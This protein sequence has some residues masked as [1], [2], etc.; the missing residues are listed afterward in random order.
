MSY[1]PLSSAPLVITVS[2]PLLV[3]HGVYTH[4]LLSVSVHAKLTAKCNSYQLY[5]VIL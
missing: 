5:L 4:D 2:L 3:V 1:A